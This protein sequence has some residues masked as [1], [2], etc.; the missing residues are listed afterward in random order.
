MAQ[1]FLLL[2]RLVGPRG[3]EVPSTQ[4]VSSLPGTEPQ[5]KVSRR[6]SH[7]LVKTSLFCTLPA[8]SQRPPSQTFMTETAVAHNPLPIPGEQRG[9]ALPSRWAPPTAGGGSL[10][11][12]WDLQGHHRR[13]AG[14]VG[15]RAGHASHT[16]LQRRRRNEAKWGET[17]HGG[18]FGS[19]QDR[20]LEGGR[21][22]GPGHLGE[23][24]SPP[25]A[26]PLRE[27]LRWALLP[28]LL[29]LRELCLHIR[30]GDPW[31]PPV[32]CEG[33][34]PIPF[35]FGPL[36]L[37]ILGHLLL[38]MSLTGRKRPGATMLR[39]GRVLGPGSLPRDLG[40]FYVGIVAQSYFRAASASGILKFSFLGIEHLKTFA[41]KAAVTLTLR[42]PC[43]E[44][45]LYK[46]CFW[47]PGWAG[48]GDP[49]AQGVPS[50]M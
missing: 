46:T 37:P 4:R 13:M 42:R 41:F 22:T 12:S 35:L 40:S 24:Q 19:G 23:W 44:K 9:F 21:L 48:W 15:G 33:S 49:C 43:T 14:E 29:A 18:R 7:V 36:P 1:A 2:P 34:G 8:S 39:A 26:Q 3:A 45:S 28:F 38:P 20:S 27:E 6:C 32:L 16:I 47:I 10:A 17:A 5:S 31:Q 50:S 11:S 25:Q 30:V